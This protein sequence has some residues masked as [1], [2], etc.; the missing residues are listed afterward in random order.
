MVHDAIAYAP[1]E[2][3]FINDIC[4]LRVTN[5]NLSIR[6]SRFSP[7]N[8]NLENIYGL[9]VTLAHLAFC[10]FSNNAFRRTFSASASNARR[11]ANA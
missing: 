3:R 11:F 6:G 1:Y 5:D 2:L 10:N 9:R 4:G 8:G 7:K